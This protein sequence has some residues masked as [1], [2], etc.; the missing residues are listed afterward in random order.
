[1]SLADLLNRPVT[2]LQRST[3]DDVVDE[4]G[5]AIADTVTIETVG[6]LQQCRRDEPA[7]AGELSVSD[8]LLVL[9]AATL[10]RTGD[11]VVVDGQVYELVGDPWI[12]RN[13]RTQTVSHIECTVRRT[14]ATDDEAPGS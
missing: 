13:P 9:P 12:A 14:A 3:G 1:M 7:G 5:N 10:I 4:Y 6:E 8:W 2:V 11:A